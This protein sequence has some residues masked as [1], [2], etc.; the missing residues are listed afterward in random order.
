MSCRLVVLLLGAQ[1]GEYALDAI[2]RCLLRL[3]FVNDLQHRCLWRMRAKNERSPRREKLLGRPEF[4][5]PQPVKFDWS[6]QIEP[7]VPGA[8]QELFPS[9]MN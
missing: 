8:A 4:E 6:H 7:V 1:L 2:R 9:H 3:R 5:I